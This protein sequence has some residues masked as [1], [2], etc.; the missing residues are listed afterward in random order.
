MLEK[1]EN[2][3]FFKHWF[4]D[5]VKRSYILRNGKLV[6]KVRFWICFVT[7]DLYTRICCLRIKGLI[8]SQTTAL[9]IQEGACSYSD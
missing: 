2:Y 9:F 7:A 3:I 6:H 1:M 8:F 5:M 4:T